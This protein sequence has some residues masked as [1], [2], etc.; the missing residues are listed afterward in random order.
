MAIKFRLPIGTVI[1][2]AKVYELQAQRFWTSFLTTKEAIYTSDEMKWDEY[3]D[4]YVIELKD[5]KDY[6]W[7]AVRPNDL[8]R[9]WT[10]I[11]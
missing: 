3:L 6:K 11:K 9:E 8:K 7:I 5:E 1:L 2:R 4:R 10:V